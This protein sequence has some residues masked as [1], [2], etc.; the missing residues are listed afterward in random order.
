MARHTCEVLWQRGDQAF[1]DLRYSRMHVLKF[2][3]GIEVPASASP[4]NVPLPYSNA[5]AVDPEEGFVGSL[6]SCHMLWFLAIAAARGFRVDRYHDRAEGDLGN[7]GNGR[8]SMTVITLRPYAAFSGS[9][10]PSAA[11]I[12]HMHHAAHEEC[13]IARSVR[14]EVRCEPRY[15]AENS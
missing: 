8:M 12:S 4:H 15:V 1:L 6:S 13:Y 7:D 2:D 5:A 14:S 9:R 3:G 10:L 11:E